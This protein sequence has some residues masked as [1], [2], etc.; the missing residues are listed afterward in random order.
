MFLILMMIVLVSSL[1]ANINI[2]S[3]A[4]TTLYVGL[5][6]VMPGTTNGYAIN[7]PTVVTG[8]GKTIWNLV[9]YKSQDSSE[10]YDYSKSN[11]Y[12]LKAGAG[13]YDANG[14][15][16]T[17]VRKEYTS[18]CDLREKSVMSNQ[19]IRLFMSRGAVVVSLLLFL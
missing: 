15:S 7:D 18:L 11:L 6:R 14:S 10:Y 3:A 8:D 9:S 19:I 1:F 16:S 13:F 17:S 5:S 2:S 12:C 4:S